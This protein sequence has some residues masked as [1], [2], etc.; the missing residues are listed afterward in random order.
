ML[1]GQGCRHF[2]LEV[3][4]ELRGAGIKPDGQPWWVEIEQPP[5]VE[6]PPMRVALHQLAIAT[7]GDYRRWLDADGRRY[8]HTIDPRSGRSIDN[9]AR[10]VTVLHARCMMA[11]AW[12]TALSVLGAD[13]GMALAEREGLAARMLDAA[14]EHM[15]PAFRAMLD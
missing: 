14:G 15:S 6:T 8:A 3:G 12:A 5:G 10:S 1:I 2:L 7:S 11:D 13:A 4:G 9:A